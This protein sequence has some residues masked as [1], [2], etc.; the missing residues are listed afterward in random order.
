MGR[1]ERVHAPST[2]EH[3]SSTSLCVCAKGWLAQLCHAHHQVVRFIVG[4]MNPRLCLSV[5]CVP[6]VSCRVVGLSFSVSNVAALCLYP[7][8]SVLPPPPRQD[9]SVTH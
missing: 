8:L 6:S 3:T 1:Q 2:S 9:T 5:A 4:R 7:E